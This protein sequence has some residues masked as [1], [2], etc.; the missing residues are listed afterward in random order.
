[1]CKETLQMKIKCNKLLFTRH[2]DVTE[3]ILQ[4]DRTSTGWS[5]DTFYLISVVDSLNVYTQPS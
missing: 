3:V 4:I 5:Q 1:M 2:P